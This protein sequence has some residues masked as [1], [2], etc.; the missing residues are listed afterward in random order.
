MLRSM[1][2]FLLILGFAFVLSACQRREVFLRFLPTEPSGWERTELLAFGV[3][4]LP[5]ASRF[6][7]Q[8]LVRKTADN[9]YAYRDLTLV[10]HQRWTLPPPPPPTA[11]A[12]GRR[13][14]VERPRKGPKPK[15]A[16]DSLLVERMDTVRCV[17]MTPD[18]HSRA[19][20]IALQQYAFALAPL[21]LPQ[22]ARAK[23][24]IRHL[25]RSDVIEGITD[26]GFSIE[27]AER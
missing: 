8:L 24:T 5:Y 3:D 1:P 4:S 27:P 12:S 20:G 26:L 7:P 14:L 21:A 17:L 15:P 6:V 18:G 13:Y 16:P 11:N 25:M 23:V 22:G 9:R 19:G 2:R 10:V